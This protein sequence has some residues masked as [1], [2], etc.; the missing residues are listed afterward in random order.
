MGT[1]LNANTNTTNT[2]QRKFKN[3]TIQILEN[4]Y[5]NTLKYKYTSI[6]PHV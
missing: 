6:W 5:L 3:N 1:Y 2:L 4:M